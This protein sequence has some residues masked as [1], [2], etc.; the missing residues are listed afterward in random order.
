MTATV[1]ASRERRGGTPQVVAAFAVIYVVWGTTYLGIRIAIETIP[2]F[3]MAGTRF[4]VAGLLI[5]GWV[6]LRGGR[7]PTRSDWK[8]GGIVLLA[9]GALRGE[10]A[11]LRAGAPSPRS[12][13]ALGYLI[14][15]GTLI[16]YSAYVWL[17]DVTT[18]AKVGTYA[19]FNPLVA[20][21]LGAWLA[22]E[23]VTARMLAGAACILLS[24]FLVNSNSFLK[25]RFCRAAAR[26][27][28]R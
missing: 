23:P 6:R 13:A 22:A 1:R 17:L 16:A 11:G 8:R 26:P 27:G 9:A 5:Y 14:V 21:I 20:L 10:W 2:P 18:P 12:L 25:R 3:L 7:R 24:I 19:Y 4:L 28:Y 15:F